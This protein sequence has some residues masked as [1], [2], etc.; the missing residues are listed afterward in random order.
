MVPRE[1]LDQK[2][3]LRRCSEFHQSIESIPNPF[4]LVESLQRRTFAHR[5]GLCAITA[6]L[7]HPSNGL[8]C[9]LANRSRGFPRSRLEDTVQ[10]CR[11]CDCH[12]QVRQ[13]S[14]F[15]NEPHSCFQTDSW[16]PHHSDRRWVFRRLWQQPSVI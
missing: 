11:T 14:F 5:F 10:C 3:S 4:Q 12:N 7:H 16:M 2:V 6:P 1:S 8:R 9:L 15:P 13:T